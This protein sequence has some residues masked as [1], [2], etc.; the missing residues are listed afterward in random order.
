MIPVD[1][2]VPNQRGIVVIQVPVQGVEGKGDDPTGT[3]KMPPWPTMVC[4][5]LTM[6]DILITSPITV[7][8]SE[9][10]KFTD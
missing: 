2:G 9:K 8:G 7:T 6:P 10:H 4:S 1:E 3:L 5:L